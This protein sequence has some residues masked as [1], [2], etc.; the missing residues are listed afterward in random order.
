MIVYKATNIVNGK[1]YVGQTTNTLEY[2]KDQHRRD[3]MRKNRPHTRFLEA[4]KEHGF[5]NFSFE[6][7]EECDT[8]EVLHSRE[9][10]WIR[11]Y[12]TTNKENGYNLDSGGIYCV[13]SES[14]KQKIS[15]SSKLSWQNPDSAKR[16]MDGLRKGTDTA[17]HRAVNNYVEWTCPTCGKALYVK[18]WEARKKRY[19]SLTCVANTE[20]NLE[21]IQSMGAAVHV[22]NL[23]RKEVIGRHI[24]EWS[25]ENKELVAQCPKN[26]IVTTLNPLLELTYTTY[27]IRDIRSL[28]ICFGVKNKKEFLQYLQEYVV[29]ENV[30]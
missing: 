9:Q 29:G 20:A 1:K 22:D 28:F 26:S 30:C 17:K 3:S 25:L 15:E 19:C 12:D 14:T 16:M 18:P 13:K 6:V 10:H 7:I 24:L 8:I 11:F 4:I 5:D 21:K 27:G 23:K 2:R